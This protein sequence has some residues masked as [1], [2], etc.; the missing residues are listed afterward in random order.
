[1]ERKGLV[2]VVILILIGFIFLWSHNEGK[3]A[4]SKQSQSAQAQSSETVTMPNTQQGN[5]ELRRRNRTVVNLT[6]STSFEET[7]S[8]HVTNEGAALESVR[9]R[10]LQYRNKARVRSLFP[11]S[12]WR[13][14]TMS[15]LTCSVCCITHL[16]FDFPPRTV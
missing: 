5:N 12:L 8:V 2:F 14:E 4:K 10:D 7:F 3:D 1:M 11:T 6:D 9:L 15:S 13:Q 16:S